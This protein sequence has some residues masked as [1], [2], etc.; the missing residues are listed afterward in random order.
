[1]GCSDGA[2]FAWADD[3]E[4][5]GTTIAPMGKGE[6]CR[7]VAALAGYAQKYNVRAVCC[8]GGLR[9]TEGEVG[10]ISDVLDMIGYD[11]TASD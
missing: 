6:V 1:M 11:E 7:F 5:D 2:Y 4:W 3:D 9:F 8:R 10:E